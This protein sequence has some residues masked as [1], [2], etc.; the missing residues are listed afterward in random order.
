MGSRIAPVLA[1]L[2]MDS[3]ERRHLY[4]GLDSDPLLY[5]RYVDDTIILVKDLENAHNLC[6]RLNSIHPMIK[7]TMDV[8]NEDGFVPFL[9]IQVRVRSGTVQ[10]KYY[11]KQT[12]KDLFINVS[13]AVSQNVKRNTVQAEL[14]RAIQR[15]SE[16]EDISMATKT[17]SRKFLR[18][19]HRVE[20]HNMTQLS[21][22]PKPQRPGRVMNLPLPFISDSLNHEIRKAASKLGIPVRIYNEGNSDLRRFLDKN[23]IQKP[24]RKRNCL[25]QDEKKCFARNVVYSVTCDLCQ[26]RYIGSTSQ[27]L[28]DRIEQHF[29][30]SAD[31]AIKEH[32]SVCNPSKLVTIQ[33][34]SRHK[35]LLN[36]RLAEGLLIDKSTDLLNRRHEMDDVIQFAHLYRRPTNQSIN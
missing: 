31:S 27:F 14:Q 4:Y 16:Q 30:P 24:C 3:L 13:S 32:I 34:L 21:H 15:C 20:T 8:P 33:I 5:L 22:K 12:K 6:Q 28:H 10:Y 17:V 23:K 26:R 11:Q 35:F 2:F 25:V 7:F 9:D 1:I 19:G 29:R 36:A 18:S